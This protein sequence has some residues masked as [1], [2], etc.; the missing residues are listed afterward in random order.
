MN[1]FALSI[2]SPVLALAFFAHLS[3]AQ[4]VHIPPLAS[5]SQGMG[6]PVEN[7]E[8]I[9]QEKLQ[10]YRALREQELIRD[11]NQLYQL[12]SE[13]KDYMDKNSTNVLSLDMLKKAEKIEKLA[14]SVRIRMKN[15]Q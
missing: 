3:A 12:T 6:V 11:T 13:L 1:R 14:H 8:Q 10:K 7:D 4:D 5:H 2:L 15:M 9:D